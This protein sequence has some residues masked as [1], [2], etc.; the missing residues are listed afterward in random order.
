ML[1]W[2]AGAVA[3]AFATIAFVLNPEVGATLIRA[4]DRRKVGHHQDTEHDHSV[5]NGTM[6]TGR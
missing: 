5:T 6:H 3:L 2:A 1:G 4:H